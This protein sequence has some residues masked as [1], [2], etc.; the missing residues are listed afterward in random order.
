MGNELHHECGIAALYWLGKPGDKSSSAG[1]A[2][3]NG[4]VTA[5]MP[6]ML[7]DLQ[8]RGQLAAGLSS[9][10]PDRDQ[11]LDTYKDTGTVTEAFRMSHPDEIRT[12]DIHVGNV[13]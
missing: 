5:M 6:A 3:S 8:N 2:L 7:L 10:N 12:H 1:R 4:D 13:I 11:L 9:Y